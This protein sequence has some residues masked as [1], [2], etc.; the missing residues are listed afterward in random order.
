MDLRTD[1]FADLGTMYGTKPGFYLLVGPD[2]KGYAPKGI[3]N[4]FRAKTSAAF[5]I[6]RV[7][8]DDSPQDKQSVQPLIDAIDVYPL[9]KYD[10]K[11]KER[12]WRKVP[13][14]ANP[15]GDSGSGETRWVFPE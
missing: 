15:T 7:F 3:A 10:G 5:I 8:Q 4:V 11:M 9:A 14:L 1:S 13:K 12:D 6:P 2:W